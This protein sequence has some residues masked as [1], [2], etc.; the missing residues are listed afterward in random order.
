MRRAR[1]QAESSSSAPARGSGAIERVRSSR[2]FCRARILVPRP[3][4]HLMRFHGVL[5]P[6][7]ELRALV[8]PAAPDGGADRASVCTSLEP[9]CD[10]GQTWRMSSDRHIPI[11]TGWLAEPTCA[12][13]SKYGRGSHIVRLDT[14]TSPTRS[15]STFPTARQLAAADPNGSTETVKSCAAPG[16]SRTEKGCL[17]FLSPRDGRL[18]SPMHRS[19]P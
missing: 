16:R 5:A 9:G 10:H 11:R 2:Q 7:A 1:W 6:H 17:N 4:L 14:C 18:S 12:A 13:A 15:R 8:I 3:R 19:S